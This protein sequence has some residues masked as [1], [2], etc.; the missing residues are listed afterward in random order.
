MLSLPRRLVSSRL[1]PALLS[2]CSAHCWLDGG[3]TGQRPGEP[4]ID[5][6]VSLSL[7]CYHQHCLR[8]LTSSPQ[9]VIYYH[10]KP[11]STTVCVSPGCLLW[12]PWEYS[13]PVSLLWPE[14]MYFDVNQFSPA[15]LIVCVCPLIWSECANIITRVSKL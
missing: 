5:L 2:V 7:P 10:S 12:K 9:N 14:N 15:T 6:L 13:L 3:K 4:V 11:L 1:W 8:P